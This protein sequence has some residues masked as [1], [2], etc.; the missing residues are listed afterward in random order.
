MGVSVDDVVDEAVALFD[1]HDERMFPVVVSTDVI[2][3]DE[4]PFDAA[5]DEGTDVGHG[6]GVDALPIGSFLVRRPE[7]NAIEI[8]QFQLADALVEIGFRLVELPHRPSVRCWPRL[9]EREDE[10]RR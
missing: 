9:D 8:D 10:I 1:V 2:E 7:E 4:L 3:D 6:V 5:E